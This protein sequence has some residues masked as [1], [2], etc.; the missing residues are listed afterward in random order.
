VTNPALDNGDKTTDGLMDGLIDANGRAT[1][2]TTTA[3]QTKGAFFLL[4]A[5]WRLFHDL[6]F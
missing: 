1:I 4:L 6:P 3:K 2:T 5:S